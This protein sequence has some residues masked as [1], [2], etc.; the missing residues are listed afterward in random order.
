M[1]I[2]AVRQFPAK[3]CQD[4]SF[5]SAHLHLTD[6]ELFRNLGLRLILKKTHPDQLPVLRRSLQVLQ[7]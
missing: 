7:T 6:P 1:C 2:P 3:L 5:P 4:L